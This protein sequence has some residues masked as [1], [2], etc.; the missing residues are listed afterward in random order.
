MPVSILIE[1]L[2]LEGDFGFPNLVFPGETPRGALGEFLPSTILGG[3]LA[4]LADEE[5]EDTAQP[6][7]PDAGGSLLRPVIN[8]AGRL[9]RSLRIPTSGIFREPIPRISQEGDG[10]DRGGTDRAPPD[11]F[12]VQA[13]PIVL[14]IRGG[15]GKPIGGELAE[16]DAEILNPADTQIPNE[17]TIVPFTLFDTIVQGVETL[18]GIDLPFIGIDKQP[19]RGGTF[20]S[21]TVQ[22]FAARQPGGSV[23]EPAAN[24]TVAATFQST[25]GSCGCVIPKA[26][27]MKISDITCSASQFIGRR[28]SSRTINSMVREIGFEKARGA[29]GL[30]VQQLGSV[31]AHRSRRRS[32]GITA[33]DKR[34]SL[35]TLRS[36]KS[37]NKAFGIH[38]HRSTKKK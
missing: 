17:E 38:S 15:N 23:F 16:V 2:P 25:S 8:F 37:L 6:R 14:R 9:A 1:Q 24:G 29:L 36:V 5:I 20:T 4:E 32:R 27:G 18:F 34:T 11:N 22:T 3:G 26:A 13:D 10:P 30:S 33:A 35:R 31:V 7:K 21:P 19:D 28:I 12:G